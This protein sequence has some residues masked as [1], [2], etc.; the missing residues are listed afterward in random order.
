MWKATVLRF[1]LAD[2]AGVLLFYHVYALASLFL[3]ALRRKRNVTH[4]IPPRI[5]AGPNR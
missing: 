1:S 4:L 5:K 2:Y 3:Q